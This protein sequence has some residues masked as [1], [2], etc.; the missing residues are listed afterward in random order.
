MSIHG[1]S[2]LQRLVYSAA[3]GQYPSQQIQTNYLNLVVE[4]PLF[5][6]VFGL[7]AVVLVCK[8]MRTHKQKA[9][10][11]QQRQMLEHLWQLSS[12]Q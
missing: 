5:L 12:T 2:G 3:E 1:S 4:A 10:L 7:T 6:M 8:R 9:A 11:E